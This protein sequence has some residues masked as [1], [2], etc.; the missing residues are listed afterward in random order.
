MDEQESGAQKANRFRGGEFI[1]DQTDSESLS[2]RLV[3]RF[4]L[5]A[6]LWIHPLGAD[7]LRLAQP[8]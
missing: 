2:L 6:V 8:F 3:D 5:A 4:A 7:C 1:A